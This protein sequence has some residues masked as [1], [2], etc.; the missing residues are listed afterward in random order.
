MH[1]LTEFRN[2]RRLT[3][4]DLAQRVGATVATLS[5]IENGTRSPSLALVARLK[6]ETGLS[7]DAFL[8]DDGNSEPNVR[9]NRTL[10]ETHS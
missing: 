3:L 10:Q 5:R 7:A 9:Q 1:A 8:P 2:A 6:A 4:R